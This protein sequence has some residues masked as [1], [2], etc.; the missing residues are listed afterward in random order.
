M[1]SPLNELESSWLL[2]AEESMNRETR[3]GRPTLELGLIDGLRRVDIL[4]KK[5]LLVCVNFL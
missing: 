5:K 4:L 1:G 2:E 3:E